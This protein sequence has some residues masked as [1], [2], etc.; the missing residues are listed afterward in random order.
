[1]AHSSCTTHIRHVRFHVQFS[2]NALYFSS[3]R[4][5]RLPRRVQCEASTQRV[6]GAIRACYVDCLTTKYQ[7]VC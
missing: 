3:K 4:P 2:S 1:M 5:P 7:S 6:E